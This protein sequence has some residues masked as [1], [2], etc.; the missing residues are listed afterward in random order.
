[1]STLTVLLMGATGQLVPTGWTEERLNLK[2][3]EKEVLALKITRPTRHICL[4]VAMRSTR[5]RA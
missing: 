1:M 5:N 3:R 2:V 4:L